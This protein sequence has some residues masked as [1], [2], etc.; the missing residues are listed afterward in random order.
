M[1]VGVLCKKNKFSSLVLIKWIHVVLIEFFCHFTVNGGW[2]AWSQ[3][4]ECRCPG[5]S[6]FGQKRTRNCNNPM[7]LNG[8][9][10]CSGPNVQKTPDCSPCPGILH[11]VNFTTYFSIL[12]FVYRFAQS[13]KPSKTEIIE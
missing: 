2:S 4:I 10:T 11:L 9:A 13:I 6:P 5:R 1:F 7:P 12:V 3:W 8:G